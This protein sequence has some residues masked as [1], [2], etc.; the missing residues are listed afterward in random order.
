[1]AVETGGVSFCPLLKPLS[2]PNLPLPPHSE[3]AGGVTLGPCFILAAQNPISVALTDLTVT[4]CESPCLY[5]AGRMTFSRAALLR[6]CG[7]F[8]A[9]WPLLRRVRPSNSFQSCCLF[10]RLLW[11]L[12]RFDRQRLVILVI[13]IAPLPARQI[14]VVGVIRPLRR[15]FRSAA[16]CAYR[17]VAPCFHP[18]LLRVRRGS[19]M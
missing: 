14:C 10:V 13:L 17:R 11:R 7:G 1:M 6:V 5:R 16:G 2:L 4:P 8:P 18:D 3:R 12:D 9:R 19:S 15:C